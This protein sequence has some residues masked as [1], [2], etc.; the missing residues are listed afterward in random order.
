CVFNPP[1]TGGEVHGA[2]GSYP[3]MDD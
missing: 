3:V 1:V 2:D